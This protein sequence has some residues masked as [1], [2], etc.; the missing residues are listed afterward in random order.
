MN[1][2]TVTR[3]AL[4]NK[5]LQLKLDENVILMAGI[6]E[7]SHNQVAETFEAVLGAVYLDSGHDVEAVKQVLKQVGLDQNRFLKRDEDILAARE[8]K[9]IAALRAAE[10]F[11]RERE[12][13]SIAASRKAAEGR[14]QANA[15][16]AE[17]IRKKTE[18]QLKTTEDQ[19]KTT[20]TSLVVNFFYGVQPRVQLADELDK[21]TIDS[22]KQ[23]T[24]TTPSEERKSHSID[25]AGRAT[26]EVKQITTV[27]HSKQHAQNWMG[28]EKK[29]LSKNARRLQ[30][31]VEAARQEEALKTILQ[32]Q[33]KEELQREREK[34]MTLQKEKEMAL[35]KEKEKV[36]QKRKEQE[37]QKE[38]MKEKE[39]ILQKQKELEAQKQ[40][41]LKAQKQKE[42]ESQKQREL[43]AQK[44]NQKEL[45]A[46]K[47]EDIKVQEKEKLEDQRHKEV[48]A[49]K[50][51]EIQAQNETEAQK[52][53]DPEAQGEKGLENQKHKDLEVQ[54]QNDKD[55]QIQ[56]EQEE[57][58]EQEELREKEKD[59]KE[60][61]EQELKAGRRKDE[62]PLSLGLRRQ[63]WNIAREKA[64]GLKRR[65]KPSLVSAIFQEQLAEAILRQRKSEKKCERRVKLREQRRI[66]WC[67]DQPENSSPASI[68]E[69]IM[70]TPVTPP[71][72]GILPEQEQVGTLKVQEP[73][74]NDPV[75]R[76]K[77]KV[78]AT[79]SIKQMETELIQEHQ[80]AW[81]TIGASTS[82]IK[83]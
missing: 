27:Q 19:S 67:E 7:A 77:S 71:E 30:R 36:L 62:K 14:R 28:Q 6:T 10:G 34:E 83:V 33:K 56:K 48:E 80:R 51:K 32:K 59:E 17:A 37:I 39:K 60:R 12:H 45:E 79:K 43:E 68:E 58:I 16:Q 47:P 23:G 44:Q 74:K 42:L 50:Q 38:R 61:E 63:A 72:K 22:P 24:V 20:W 76:N 11:E 69:N 49:E 66:Q 15:V 4:N 21:K 54:E 3:V 75:D 40:K 53:K 25:F 55:R 65:G 46:Q 29:G 1:L 81:K 57:Q 64:A 5:G 73:A 82:E 18:D 41:E 31:R 8:K 13:K 52:Q 78:N 26:T 35:Q 2:E 9:E 70:A